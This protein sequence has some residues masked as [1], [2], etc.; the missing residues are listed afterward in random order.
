VAYLLRY[1]LVG[2]LSVASL[3]AFALQ[4]FDTISPSG[5][6]GTASVGTSSVAAKTVRNWNKAIDLGN[7]QKFK[8]GAIE[9]RNYGWGTIRTGI[10]KLLKIK[11]SA[12][13]VNVGIMAALTGVGYLLDPANNSIQKKVKE[14]EPS[15]SGLTGF[16]AGETPYGVQ[17]SPAA[18]CQAYATYLAGGGA[19]GYYY[20]HYNPVDPYPAK[21][22]SFYCYFT[23]PSDPVASAYT[24]VSGVGPCFADNSCIYSDTN[25]VLSPSEID[26]FTSTITDKNIA[27]GVAL[28]L[29]S[30]PD[31]Q[32]FLKP[33][34]WPALAGDTVVT[35][36]PATVTGETTVSTKTENG[37]T[38]TT[39]KAVQYGLTYT[40]GKTAVKTTTTTT[41]AVDGVNTSTV[42]ESNAS[43]TVDNSP[44]TAPSTE[45]APAEDPITDCA[46]MPTVCAFL[47][48]FKTPE[49]APADVD[50]PTIATDDLVKTYAG[51]SLS[52]SC[53]AP[54]TV[55]TQFTGTISIPVNALCDLASLIRYLV[56]SA[57]GLLAAFIISGTR[58]A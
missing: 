37:H 58:R 54:F 52:N 34:S 5:T 12:L 7:G 2:L 24:T 48:W 28:L 32:P 21:S 17:S 30:D 38:T 40:P 6:A 23:T 27:A 13:A 46:F 33:Q 45:T 53:P 9:T 3:N 15:S 26:S 49:A 10:S 8:F 1:C 56:I 11:P 47:D 31:L 50:L 36:G 14:P 39:T 16:T 44:E 20:S 43:G 22:Q 29:E 19:L 57:A 25:T 51:P 41:T 35:S 42:I 18:A 4:S 55:H